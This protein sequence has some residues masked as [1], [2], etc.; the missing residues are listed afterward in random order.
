MKTIE[1]ILREIIIERLMLPVSAEELP[2]DAS[3]FAPNFAGGLELDSLA[4]LEIMAAISDRFQL[5]LD[6]M[7]T[8]DFASITSLANYLRRHGISDSQIQ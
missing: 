2:V 5:P 4:S 1:D 6:D 8:E 3:L 7:E